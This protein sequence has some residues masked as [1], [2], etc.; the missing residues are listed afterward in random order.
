[1]IK[2]EFP[3]LQKVLRALATAPKQTRDA[4]NRAIRRSIYKVQNTALPLTPIDTGA[5]RRSLSA[6]TSFRDF[7]GEIYPYMEYAIYVHEGTYKMRARPF[8]K[9]AMDRDYSEVKRIFESELGTG[10]DNIVKE[11]R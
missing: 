2:I 1:M 8:L 3:N 6:G 9:T 5:L 11:A 7:Y 4:V 10:L